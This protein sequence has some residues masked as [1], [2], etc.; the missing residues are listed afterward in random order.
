M[1]I[2]RS[3]KFFKALFPSVSRSGAALNIS[4]LSRRNM[5]YFAAWIAL[6]TWM[7]CC[8]LPGGIHLY[9]QEMPM[10]TTSLLAVAVWLII[11]P[12]AVFLANGTDYVPKTI[13]SSTFL[14]LSFFIR[15]FFDV[16]GFASIMAILEAAAFAHVFVSCGYGFFMVLNNTEKFYAMILAIALPQS[17]L[18]LHSHLTFFAECPQ[19]QTIIS[20][21]CMSVIFICALDFLKN[22]K[23]LPLIPKGK[24][25]AKAY[26][27]MPVL[28]IVFTLCDVL[29]PFAVQK[30]E[31][32]VSQPLESYFYI[33]VILGIILIIYLQ[34]YLALNIASMLNTAFALLALG[35]A[36]TLTAERYPF[37]AVHSAAF[38]GVSYSLAMV[39]I[40][41]LAG[42]MSKKLNSLLFYRI[43][44]FSSTLCYLCGFWLVH[45]LENNPLTAEFFSL[46]CLVLFF[47]F[48]PVIVK[49]LREG[50]WTDDTYRNDVTY[51]SRL[52]QRLIELNISPREQILCELLLQGC[53]LRQC[54]LIMEV[55]Y[56]TANT[57]CTSLYRKLHINSRAELLILFTDCK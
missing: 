51:E 44:I 47:M 5:P 36:S 27:L 31:E 12:L 30:M 18:F 21:C 38:F 14:L 54:A 40:Y 57:Y 46:T 37:L 41:Y 22:G 9:L 48:S 34:K 6:F 10:D 39:N 16:D 29:A 43:G 8:F 55:A 45:S 32:T 23:S 42:L 28:F 20:I 7:Y 56:P 53:T 19:M 35:F 25:P 11:C 13:F 3:G 26:S 15:A 17:V 49:M 50:E 1:L 24:F 4:S 33:G 52:R 2:S